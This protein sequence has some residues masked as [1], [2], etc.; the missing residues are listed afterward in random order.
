MGST[1][2]LNG[3]FAYIEDQENT[4]VDSIAINNGSL[5]YERRS[6]FRG[7]HILLIGEGCSTFYFEEGSFTIA[8]NRF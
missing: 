1:E 6:N 4:L 8:Q 5:K 7:L 2:E 3:K